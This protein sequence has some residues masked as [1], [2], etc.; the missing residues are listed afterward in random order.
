MPSGTRDQ[1]GQQRHPQPERDRDRQLFLDQLQ[2]RHLAIETLAE[3]EAGVVPEHQEK[4]LVRRLVEAEL[5]LQLLMN[6]WS[7][8]W[9]PRYFEVSLPPPG[10][11]A[12]RVRLR[13]DAIAGAAADA[14]AGGHLVAGD[15]RQ[16]ALDRSARRELDD[17]EVDQH[18]P[19]Q[20]RD[21]EQQAFDQV[22]GHLG[23]AG[24][25]SDPFGL[26]PVDGSCKALP[27]CSQLSDPVMA[28]SWCR[29]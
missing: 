15:L 4:A 23:P 19:E 1:V 17:A 12:G 27:A 26:T 21:D 16:H 10:C 24:E 28:S 8:P 18:D 14:R 22:G 29:S 2:H 20:G 3:I 7:R 5:L 13:G 6:S 9:A 11:V 25:V